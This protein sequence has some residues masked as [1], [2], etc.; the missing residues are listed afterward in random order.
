MLKIIFEKVEIKSDIKM[1]KTKPVQLK[2]NFPILLSI[3][4]L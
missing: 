1:N 2:L 3:F 4:F